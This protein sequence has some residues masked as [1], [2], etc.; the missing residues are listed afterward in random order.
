MAVSDWIS[1]EQRDER[2]LGRQIL[3][4]LDVKDRRAK[5][6]KESGAA[7]WNSDDIDGGVSRDVEGGNQTHPCHCPPLDFRIRK[8]RQRNGQNER[9]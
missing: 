2:D 7:R 6:T 5:E 4:K 3:A 1:S 8:T 9:Q